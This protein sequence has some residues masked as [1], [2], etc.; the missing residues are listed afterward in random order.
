MGLYDRDWCR[1]AYEEKYKKYNGDFSLHS[2]PQKQKN[3]NKDIHFEECKYCKRM[4]EI[5][6][7][8]QRFPHYYWDCPHCHKRNRKIHTIWYIIG[9]SIILYVILSSFR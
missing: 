5:K 3:D 9:I 8:I 2:K 7:S 4:V 6:R 1:E